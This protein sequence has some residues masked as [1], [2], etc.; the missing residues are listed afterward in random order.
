MRISDELESGSSGLSLTRAFD[1]SLESWEASGY[2]N[3]TGPEFHIYIIYNFVQVLHIW[4]LI[5]YLCYKFLLSKEAAR[6]Q[7]EAEEEQQRETEDQARRESAEAE[8]E[9]EERQ[10]AAE[11]RQRE[12]E[13]AE[14]EEEDRSNRETAQEAAKQYA[15]EDAEDLYDTAEA[16]VTQEQQPVRL[17]Q[18]ARPT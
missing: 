14:R 2:E 4:F 9:E 5:T 13:E 16:V 1:F 8:R 7:E 10:R 6:E 3:G 18:S 17:H 15:Q 11:E 12:A